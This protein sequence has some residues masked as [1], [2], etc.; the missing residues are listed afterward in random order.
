M[1]DRP[2]KWAQPVILDG[3]PNMHKVSAILYR[4]AQPT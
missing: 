4:S 1:I 2:E 3:V